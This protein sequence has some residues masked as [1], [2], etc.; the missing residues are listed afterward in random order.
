MEQ[1]KKRKLPDWILN[2][3][4]KT[5]NDDEQ[6]EEATARENAITALEIL[7]NGL[8]RSYI[9]KKEALLQDPGDE[10][11]DEDDEDDDF[12][13]SQSSVADVMTSSQAL[14]IMG[15]TSKFKDDRKQLILD[16]KACLHQCIP[17]YHHK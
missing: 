5:D 3:I 1:Q 13:L 16:L 15:G 17:P 14:A 10:D 4:I 12:Q 8:R 6:K 9:E 7:E 2:P 11:D